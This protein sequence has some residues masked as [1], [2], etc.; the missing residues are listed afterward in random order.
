LGRF[1]SDDRDLGLRRVSRVT[2]WLVAA[3]VAAVGVVTAVVADAAPGSSRTSK[4]TVDSSGTGSSGVGTPAPT[5]APTTT[6]PFVD[7]GNNLNPPDDQG[8]TPPTDP[9][10]RVHRSR[11]ADSG[12][13]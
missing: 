2:K 7:S 8:L 3:S 4:P 6:L 5:A 13:S 12:G 9:P 10:V 11:H 1:G